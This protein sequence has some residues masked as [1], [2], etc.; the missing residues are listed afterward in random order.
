MTLR[1]RLTIYW[2]AVLALLLIIAG[3]T[4]FLLFQRQQWARL[5]GALLEEADTAAQLIARMGPDSAVSIAVRLAAER[6]LGP[7]R[8]VW[9]IGGGT[10]IA[11][12]G[13]TSAS[14]PVIKQ[15][16]DRNMLLDSRDQRF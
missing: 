16:V 11:A 10:E 8:R 4:V 9:I 1:L 7:S 6:D 2:A 13:D 12:A 5:D 15:P 3:F 14:L